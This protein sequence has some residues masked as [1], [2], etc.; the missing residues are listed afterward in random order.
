M[1]SYS[2]LED[3][4]GKRACSLSHPSHFLIPIIVSSSW[5]ECV[6]GA[7]SFAKKVRTE[8]WQ[9]SEGVIW[10]MINL[11]SEVLFQNPMV[12]FDN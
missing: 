7:S 2:C 5:C 10:Q 12:R 1:R 4:R 6:L 9:F 11:I 3:Q 8:H